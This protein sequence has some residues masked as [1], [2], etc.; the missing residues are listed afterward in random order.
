MQQIIHAIRP[1]NV[2]KVAG[3]GNKII[4]ILDTKADYYINLVPGFKYWDM[5]AAEALIQ[6][7]MGIVTDA[8]SRPLIYDHTKNDY[9]IREGIIVAKNKKAYDVCAKRIIESMGKDIPTIHSQMLLES[10]ARREKRIQKNGNE[11]NAKIIQVDSS[12]VN[13]DSE[14][15]DDTRKGEVAPE[16]VVKHF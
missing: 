4:Y 10:D 12:I 7:R 5:C 13:P 6:A 14:L 1:L 2:A 16:T 3:S 15:K 11:H 9:T 8:H